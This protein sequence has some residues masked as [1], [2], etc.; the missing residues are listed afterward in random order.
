MW[1]SSAKGGDQKIQLQLNS[2]DSDNI[3]GRLLVL[4]KYSWPWIL[5]CEER[6]LDE[7]SPLKMHPFARVPM[8]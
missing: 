6:I 8:D 5:V 1:R 2:C 4:M 3:H 7:K